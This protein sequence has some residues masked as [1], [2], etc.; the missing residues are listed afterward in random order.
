MNLRRKLA[1]IEPDSAPDSF[2]DPRR[3]W[4]QPNGL[5]AAGGDLAPARLLAAYRQGIFPWY[6]A[7][8]PILW[9]SPDPRA[10]LLPEDFHCSRRLG[11][12]LRSGRFAVS[13]DQ[14]F[15]R[16]IRLCASTRAAQGT[17]L[18]PAMIEAY[19]ALHALGWAHSIEAWRDG[20]LAG[21]VY[22]VALGGVFFGESMVSLQPDASKVALAGLA[23][24][25]T[26][27]GIGMIDCQ[28][29]NGHLAR[30]GSRLLPR[31][32]FLARLPDLAAAGP[33]QRLRAMPPQPTEVG[34][35]V[36]TQG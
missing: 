11:R 32:E 14:C 10:V 26:D 3:A 23:R 17:W 7:G 15:G 27:A 25:A 24:M 35:A 8:E 28:V 5:L 31:E 1:W 30:L 21:G 9:W 20:E 12:T 34:L 16:L 36:S 22:G 33:A 13:V 2:P 6:S 4:R 19:E 29:P 18:G